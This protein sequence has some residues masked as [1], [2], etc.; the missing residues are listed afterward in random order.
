MKSYYSAALI[1]AIAICSIV[2]MGISYETQKKTACQ[3]A[4]ILQINSDTRPDMA[5]VDGYGK[6]GEVYLGQENGPFKRSDLV[7]K[8]ERDYIQARKDSLENFIN[9]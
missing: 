5:L 7:E 1:G 2:M 6:V 8:E 4:Y 9:R 3:T